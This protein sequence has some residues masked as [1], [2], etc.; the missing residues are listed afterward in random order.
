[1]PKEVVSANVF[2]IPSNEFKPFLKVYRG[3]HALTQTYRPQANSLAEQTFKC[4][5]QDE[6]RQR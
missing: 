5:E 2:Q 4:T 3:K 1:M 6:L